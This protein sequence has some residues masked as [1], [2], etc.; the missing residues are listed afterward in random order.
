MIN[1]LCSVRCVC[2]LIEQRFYCTCIGV[3][4][5][6]CSRYKLCIRSGLIDEKR[7]RHRCFRRSRRGTCS[8]LSDAAGQPR[9]HGLLHRLLPAGHCRRLRASQ[10]R[11]GAVCPPGDHRSG[12]GRVGDVSGYQRIPRQSRF[13]SR[14]AVRAG[15]LCHN[16]RTGLSGL[17]AADGAA[18]GRRRSERAGGSDWL[19]HRHLHR[20]CVSEKRLHAGTFL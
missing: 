13:R 18:S 20:H 5:F 19:Y 8:H 15:R 9:Q 2:L 4:V 10:R 6:T 1:Q 14:S 7:N 16:R 12:A 17:P 3:H 11:Q